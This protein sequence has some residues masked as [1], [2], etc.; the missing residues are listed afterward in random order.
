MRKLA[1]GIVGTAATGGSVDVA[2]L[3]NAASGN[4]R[5]NA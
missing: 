3:P 1:H 5:R 4:P 2:G